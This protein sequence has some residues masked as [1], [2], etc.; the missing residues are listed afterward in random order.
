MKTLRV[1]SENSSIRSRN[2]K[3][4]TISGSMASKH[5]SSRGIKSSRAR[6]RVIRKGTTTIRNRIR[7]P[8]PTLLILI[9]LSLSSSSSRKKIKKEV[10]LKLADTYGIFDELMRVSKNMS[11]AIKEPGHN[12]KIKA[13]VGEEQKD[14][15]SFVKL[16][17]HK[18][19]KDTP[20]Q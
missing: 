14:Y 17:I 9:V 16:H 8:S 1:P 3:T 12:F 6:S 7:V 20:L 19:N 18:K 13:V 5:L 10:F 11:F 4:V 2:I 15:N